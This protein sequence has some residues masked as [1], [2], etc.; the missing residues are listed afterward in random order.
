MNKRKIE[1]TDISAAKN[2]GLA[3]EKELIAIAEREKAHNLKVQAEVDEYNNN[4]GTIDSKFKSKTF[5]GNDIIVRLRK[6]DYLIKDSGDKLKDGIKRDNQFPIQQGDGNWTTIDNPLPYIYSGIICAMPPF[7]ANEYEVNS[8][9]KLEAGMEI[10][11]DNVSLI[12]N[13]YYLDKTKGDSRPSEQKLLKGGKMFPNHEGYF[14]IS[15]YD[16]ESIG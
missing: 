1:N 11:I 2:I 15:V 13:R 7:V 3:P 5:I 10:E 4:I 6:E 12:E 9:V 16:I 14:K 8:G